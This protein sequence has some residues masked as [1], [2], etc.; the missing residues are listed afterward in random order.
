M[1]AIDESEALLRSCSEAYIK[2]RK[3]S[4]GLVPTFKVVLE[5]ESD[6]DVARL[7]EVLETVLNPEDGA[8]KG[9][10]RLSG[11]VLAAAETQSSRMGTRTPEQSEE[12]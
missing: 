1:V 4:G 9:C 6:C 8:L 3:Y 12:D 2:A 10:S 5:I 7:K 11:S